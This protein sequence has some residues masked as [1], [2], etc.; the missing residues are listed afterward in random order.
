MVHGTFRNL[1]SSP[2][3]RELLF[4]ILYFTIS[5]LS[6]ALELAGV[7]RVI[8]YGAYLL[9]FAVYF[10][11]RIKSLSLDI[12][13][14]YLVVTPVVALSLW[15]NRTFVSSQ[16]NLYSVIILFLPAYYFYRVADKNLL[17]TAIR[18][19]SYL[20][21]AYLL[22]YF[23]V[24]V[25]K[26]DYS[27]D[28]GYWI[29]FPICVLWYFSL[30]NKKLIDIALTV[31]SIVTL[32]IGGSR[33]SLALTIAC[34][35]FIAVMH[36]ENR[37][38]LARIALL[39]LT[40][41]FLLTMSAVQLNSNQADST[42]TT[43]IISRNLNKLISGDFLD[44]HTRVPLY[45]QGVE[46]VKKNLFGYGMLGSRQLITKWPYPHSLP[47]ELILDFGLFGG[48]A[49][50]VLL[51]AAVVKAFISF[52]KTDMI[53]L[54]SILIVIDLGRLLVSYSVYYMDT[55]PAI[56]ALAASTMQPRKFFRSLISK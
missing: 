48:F 8:A 10:F 38:L 18:V 37:K 23:V 56:L 42:E 46:L 6:R 5:H 17:P 30:K 29:A 22:P 41:G 4:L 9:I 28:Y 50:M 14:Y 40:T 13:I 39:T 25:R 44:M 31:L 32:L 20:S 54:V 43:Q 27:M 19:A 1:R 35:V 12:I 47:L 26:I 7:S 55:F 33:A 51:L 11:S 24:V 45:S 3:Q 2:N 49:L 16:T 15:R 34:C 52:R 21:L 53:L 36:I